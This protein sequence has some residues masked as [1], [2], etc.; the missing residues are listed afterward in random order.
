MLKNVSDQ[1]ND[2]LNQIKKKNVSKSVNTGVGMEAIEGLRFLVSLPLAG[3]GR[4]EGG[5]KTQ[6][7]NRF[8]SRL[9]TLRKMCLEFGL[10]PEV[11]NARLSVSPNP[12]GDP[13]KVIRAVAA[14]IG[15]DA[16][17]EEEVSALAAETTLEAMRA[18]PRT[19]CDHWGMWGIVLKRDRAKNFMLRK[20]Q[21]RIIRITTSSLGWTKGCVNLAPGAA[22]VVWA[23]ELPCHVQIPYQPQVPLG[24]NLVTKREIPDLSHLLH[25]VPCGDGQTKRKSAT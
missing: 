3:T 20:G 24:P 23:S 12:K 17:S 10:Y 8:Y 5:E 21:F 9:F 4:T 19:N 18:N 22:M 13:K 14:F 25:R 16:G 6:P 15:A 2:H 7:F 1:P 11:K